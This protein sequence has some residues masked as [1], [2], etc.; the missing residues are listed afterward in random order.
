M[1]T[2]GADV[3]PRSR[4]WGRYPDSTRQATMGRRRARRQSHGS[5]WHWKQTDCW[6][7][8]PPG[9]KQR[10]PLFDEDGQRIR[11]KENKKAAELALAR[12]QRAGQWQPA[13][14]APAH[15][16]EWL[17]AKVCSEYIQYCQRGAANGTVSAE[18]R[19]AVVVRLNDLGRYCGAL[20][21]AQFK[22]GHVR[23]WLDRHP[24]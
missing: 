23:E 9:T 2:P 12:V 4:P 13:A 7:Y 8:T 22:K 16:E 6:Y 17:V 24:S 3:N 18:H 11:G 21:V 14:A 15:T 20:P 5:A 10:V 19:D 1:A